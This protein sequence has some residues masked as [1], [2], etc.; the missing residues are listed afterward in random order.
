[1]DVLTSGGIPR[2]ETFPSSLHARR[3]RATWAH[4]YLPGITTNAG[5]TFGQASDASVAFDARHNV[6]MIS[7]LGLRGST[8]DVL[9]SRSTD[10]G[11]TWSNPVIAA[12]GRRQ[13]L[14]DLA[15]RRRAHR[16]HLQPRDV[17]P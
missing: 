8:V 3:R 15:D 10:G 6:W 12:T 11:L 16:L 2:W 17:R 4:G 7:S 1:M 14:P 9:V 5:G 13:R